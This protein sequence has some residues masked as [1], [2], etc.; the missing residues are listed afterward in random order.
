MNAL[1]SLTD[2]FR[3]YITD[4][5]SLD[6]WA[7]DGAVFSAQGVWVDGFELEYTVIIFM[8]NVHVAPQTVMMHLVSWMR[9]YDPDRLE[10]GLAFPTFAAEV[11]DGGCCDIKIRM[12]LRESYSL[13]Q[14]HNGDWKQGEAR[15]D[16][17][18][19]FEPVVDPDLL[20]ELVHFVGH[21]DDLP[22]RADAQAEKFNGNI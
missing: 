10:K 4:A 14:S 18:S 22:E 16:C 15:Y 11:L 7:E 17:V 20:G 2:L 3:R 1:Q 8:Q 12:D 19:D 21:T 5:A 6:V 9:K 13:E